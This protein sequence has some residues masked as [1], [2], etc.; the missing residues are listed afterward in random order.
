M[1]SLEQRTTFDRNKKLDKEA[2]VGISVILAL[3]GGIMIRSGALGTRSITPEYE[4][5]YKGNPAAVMH[6]D[7]RFGDD[8]YWI[9]LSDGSKIYVGEIKSDDGKTIKMNSSGKYKVE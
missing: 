4:F 1:D 9:E 2:K 7:V 5:K 8:H 6:E 3:V